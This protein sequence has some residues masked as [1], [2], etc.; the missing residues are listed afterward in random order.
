MMLYLQPTNKICHIY[1]MLFYSVDF[2]YHQITHYLKTLFSTLQICPSIFFCTIRHT[3]LQ[4]YLSNFIFYRLI[5]KNF[6]TN[7]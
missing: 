2:L 7:E 1:T 6:A 5:L 4:F 3:T